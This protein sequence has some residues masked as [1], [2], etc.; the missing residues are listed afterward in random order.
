M[1][2][3]GVS[4]L[5]E[6]SGPPLVLLMGLGADATAWAPHVEAWAQQHRCIAIDNRGAD[7]S[8]LGDEIL[9]TRAMADDTAR[10]IEALELGAVQVVGISM[11]AC[12]AQ[13]LALARPELVSRMALVAPWSRCDPFTQSVLE[14]LSRV[15]A[16]NDTRAFN[17]LLRNTVWTPEW[18]NAHSTTMESALAA[19]PTMSSDA[20]A[21]QAFACAR[22][23]ADDRLPEL[24]TPTLVTLGTEDVFIRDALSRRVADRMPN[25][26]THAFAG[27][28]HVHHW[29]ALD[30]FNTLIEKWMR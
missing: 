16:T 24:Q 23:D 22:H 8:P 19:I 10:L 26:Q 21:A 14:V 30:E 18:I 15:R 25:A 11:G 13:E 17:E 2:A 20:F 9:S 29:E 4:Y 3:A 6:G 7:G 12:I 28:G 5:D 27:L 1:I